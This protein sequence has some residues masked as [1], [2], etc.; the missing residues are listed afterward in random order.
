MEQPCYKCGQ[1]V[2][3]GVVFCPHCSAP[4]IRVVVGEPA[5][6]GGAV[7]LSSDASLAVPDSTALARAS[8]SIR[9]S[10]AVRPC[11]VAGLIAALA[12][13]FR[14]V[15]PPIAV[16]GAGFLAVAIYRR[17]NPDAAIRAGSGARLGALCGVFCFGMA[18]VLGAVA[19]VVLRKGGVVHQTLLDAV[20]QAAVRYP[21]PQA[22]SAV[23]FMRSPAGPL[24]MLVFLLL[25]VCLTFLLLGTLGGALGGLTF[26][27]RDKG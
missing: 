21:D 1:I 8:L 3:E 15:V 25:F 13:V 17:R 24:M 18:T 23:D 12:M 26:G 20:Q 27:H 5:A 2:E 9:W 22:Q 14:L 6:S 7:A 11:A 16:F 19:L 10:Q 4:Q